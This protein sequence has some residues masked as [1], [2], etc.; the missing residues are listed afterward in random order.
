MARK[1]SGINCGVRTERIGEK[2][3]SEN[4]FLRSTPELDRIARESENPEAMRQ[5]MKAELERTGVITPL[6]RGSQY[7]ATLLRAPDLA[8]SGSSLPDS[9][10]DGFLTR[11]VRWHE[12]TGKKTL[13]I[14]ARTLAEL[15]ELERQVT[16]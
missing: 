9:T 7:G 6:E 16:R 8:N 11:E 5:A 13:I 10:S 3:M 14:R 1:R 15:D 12:S 2:T 4:A